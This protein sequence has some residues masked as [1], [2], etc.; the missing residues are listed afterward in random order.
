VKLRPLVKCA[1]SHIGNYPSV[2]ERF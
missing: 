1:F 2:I